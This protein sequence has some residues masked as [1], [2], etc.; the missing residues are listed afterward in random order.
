MPD[1]CP[2]MPIRPWSMTAA[3]LVLAETTTNSDNDITGKHT[4]HEADSC[5]DNEQLRTSHAIN[6]ALVDMMMATMMAK[7]PSAE[8][9]I[10]ITRILTKRAPFCASARAQPLPQIPTQTPHARLPKPQQTPAQKI[11]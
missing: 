3:A 7:M 9:K 6:F 11:A 1:Y 2:P 5:V 4:K 8:A 10:S